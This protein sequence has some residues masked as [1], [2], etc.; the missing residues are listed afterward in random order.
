M[1]QSLSTFYTRSH[2]HVKKK[3]AFLFSSSGRIK[4]FSS[5]LST[6][7]TPCF[8][9]TC[10]IDATTWV[11]HT[12]YFSYFFTP[13]HEKK[14]HVPVTS[15]C[16]LINDTSGTK[17]E[18]IMQ[19]LLFL[20]FF[21]F[22]LRMWTG[23]IVNIPFL[24]KLWENMNRFNIQLIKCMWSESNSIVRNSQIAF[25]TKAQK[26]VFCVQQTELYLYNSQTIA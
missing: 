12:I 21:L 25:A 2:H 22:R 23:G 17:I 10:R 1:F 4:S 15:D 18:L 3:K 16:W 19:A 11:Y 24:V 14:S 6:S 9:I 5:A 8:T 7:P 20:F 26:A 13:N